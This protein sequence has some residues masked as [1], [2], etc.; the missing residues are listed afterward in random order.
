MRGPK[1]PLIKLGP[2]HWIFNILNESENRKE[3]NLIY[4]TL[5]P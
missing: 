4:F 2:T 3:L 5:I 1:L